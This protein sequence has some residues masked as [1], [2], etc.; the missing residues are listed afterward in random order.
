[1]T[2]DQLAHVEVQLRFKDVFARLQRHLKDPT[3]SH[4]ASCVRTGIPWFRVAASRKI[5]DKSEAQFRCL[6]VCACQRRFACL[7]AC[8]HVEGGSHACVCVC[9]CVCRRRYVACSCSKL[10]VNEHAHIR[11]TATYIS[12]HMTASFR[13]RRV[14]VTRT[15]S[16]AK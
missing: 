1:M 8:V 5:D 16:S 13:T 9:V 14:P 12:M 7:C 10:P 11:Q 15:S 2:F 6:C 3:I 4:T